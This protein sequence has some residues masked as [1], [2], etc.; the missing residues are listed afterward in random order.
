M[1]EQ[2]R[3]KSAV[4]FRDVA[5]PKG[6]P[7]PSGPM[8]RRVFYR[9][10]TFRLSPEDL[11]AVKPLGITAVHDLRGPDEIARR[12]DT[13][14]P[15]A[16]WRHHMVPGIAR[17]V[18]AGFTSAA[19]TRDAMVEHYR[20]FVTDPAKRAGFAALLAAL[21]EGRGAQV[22]HC[23]EGK[24]RTGWAAMLLQRLAGV[25]EDDVMADFR[26]TDELLLPE[27]DR[28]IA[29]AQVFFGDRPPEVYFPAVI[30]DP[31]YLEAGMEQMEAC[32]GG[33]DGYLHDGLGL[34]EAQ[35]DRLRALLTG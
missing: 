4:N 2:V 35:T 20:G 14:P 6:Y 8:R 15:G 30:A 17:R 1:Q 19:Q 18:A 12:P 7:T 23:S 3:L 5:G 22:F 11:A 29:N 34:T 33:L 27:R 21:S 13:P 26:L 28:V 16:V 10:N 25:G 31:A 9:S 24:D 32:H